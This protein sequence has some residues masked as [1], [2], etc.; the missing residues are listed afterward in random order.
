MFIVFAESCHDPTGIVCRHAWKKD[1][2]M[3]CDMNF[4]VFMVYGVVFSPEKL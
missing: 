2:M 1:F 3:F 4:D